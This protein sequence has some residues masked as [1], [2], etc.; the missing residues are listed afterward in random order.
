MREACFRR[1]VDDA[2]SL[3][4]V[5]AGLANAAAGARLELLL[6]LCEAAVRVAQ[7]QKAE[8]RA[9]VL[10]RLQAGVRAELVRDIPQPPLDLG[11]VRWHGTSP[12]GIGAVI[13]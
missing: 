2:A 1:E 3:E 7:K 12:L 10:G 5:W 13:I 4:S 11:D 8:D 9:G 6:S